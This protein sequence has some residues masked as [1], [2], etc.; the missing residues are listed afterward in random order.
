V[1][2]QSQDSTLT[3]SQFRMDHLVPLN[4]LPATLLQNITDVARVEKLAPSTQLHARNEH[5]WMIYLLDGC[6]SL[7]C[8]DGQD[9]TLE[10]TS[11][12]ARNP[13][14]DLDYKTVTAK[15]TQPSLVVRVDRNMFNVCLKQNESSYTVVEEFDIHEVGEVLFSRVYQ[16]YVDRKLKLPTLPV[17]ALKIRE[18]VK[19]PELGVQDISRIVQSD[20]PL[21]ARLIQMANSPIYRGVRPSGTAQEA[22]V[23]LGAKTTQNLTFVMAISSLFMSRSE[24]IQAQMIRLHSYSTQLAAAC[25]VIA[26]LCPDLD[27][28]RAMLLGLVSHIGA[29][30]ILSYAGEDSAFTGNQSIVGNILA[31]LCSITS[32]LVLRQWGFDSE[33]TLICENCDESR[34]VDVDQPISYSDVLQAAIL[35]A[36]ENFLGGE[37]QAQDFDN[38]PVQQKFAAAGIIESRDLFLEKADKEL[39]ATRELLKP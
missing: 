24:V 9:R 6:L 7:K 39:A 29:I 4:S 22:I 32:G 35:I 20:P 33:L 17:V 26:D 2:S 25:Y 3:L 38:H 28:E 14:F 27:Q 16:A 19:N 1:A 30:P 18:V 13:I 36:P 11:N 31:N 5:R 10:S 23:R 15:P 34:I 8:S 21:T 12:N 37:Q